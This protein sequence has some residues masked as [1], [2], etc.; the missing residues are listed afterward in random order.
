[1]NVQMFIFK[2]VETLIEFYCSLIVS[3]KVFISDCLQ[4]N[5][6]TNGF[7]VSSLK[8]E[9]ELLQSVTG[10]E[11]ILWM[12]D[13]LV[14]LLTNV[15]SWEKE[16]ETSL[17]TCGININLSNDGKSVLMISECKW[18][19]EVFLVVIIM[20]TGSHLWVIN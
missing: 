19:T 10:E 4:E 6:K 7:L 2:S 12:R 13:C 18:N 16:I 20:N 15:S 11:S 5:L 3:L 8:H 9:M 1:M 17:Q 14:Q